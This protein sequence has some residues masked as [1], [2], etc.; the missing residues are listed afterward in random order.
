MESEKIVEIIERKI[1]AHYENGIETTLMKALKIA[2]AEL[3]DHQCPR[4]FFLDKLWPEC[5]WCP[6]GREDRYDVQRDIACFTRWAIETAE[7][8][9]RG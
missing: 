7:A 8:E 9:G 6:A 5:M 3:A 1:V 4:E 2:C